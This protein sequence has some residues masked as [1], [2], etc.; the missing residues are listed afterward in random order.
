MNKSEKR[1]LPSSTEVLNPGRDIEGNRTKEW[2][3]PVT[4]KSVGRSP[5]IEVE[6][7]FKPTALPK[8]ERVWNK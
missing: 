2:R 4:G 7:R 3:G 5:V 1:S 6:S 8:A